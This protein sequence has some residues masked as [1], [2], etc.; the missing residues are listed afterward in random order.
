E[1]FRMVPARLRFEHAGRRVP[2][3][4]FVP[5]AELRRVLGADR[6]AVPPPSD[7]VG[8]TARLADILGVRAGDALRV[9]VLEADRPVREVTV[10]GRVDE[11]LGLNAYM[12]VGA[13]H[14]LV[15]EHGSWSGAFLRVD[16]AA[17]PTLHAELKRM[18]AVAGITSRLAMRESFA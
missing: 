9:E 8:L 1:P 7:G 17:A 12:E 4:G 13:L 5:D 15:R 10:A 6:T 3:F 16:A 14:R 2:L 18:P 11:L